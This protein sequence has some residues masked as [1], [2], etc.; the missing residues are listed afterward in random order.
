V[1]LAPFVK[2]YDW[3]NAN[4]HKEDADISLILRTPKKTAI[5]RLPSAAARD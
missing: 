3:L 5:Q 4:H 1:E 2:A